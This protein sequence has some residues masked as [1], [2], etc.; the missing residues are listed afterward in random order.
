MA[1][2]TFD[3]DNREVKGGVDHVVVYPKSKNFVGFAWDGVS[4]VGVNPNGGDVNSIWADNICYA[5]IRG[6]EN[7]AGSIKAYDY[8]DEW[9][10]CIG[11]KTHGDYDIVHVHGQ[12]HD[13]FN[14]A[15]RTKTFD[16]DGNWVM[17]T[18]HTLFGLSAGTSE[19]TN[20]TLEE[21]FEPEEFSFDFEGTPVRLG[22]TDLYACDFDFDVPV[23]NDK[24]VLSITDNTLVV[25]GRTFKKADIATAALYIGRLYGTGTAGSGTDASCVSTTALFGTTG[26]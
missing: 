9:K 17:S 4:E 24:E 18:Y 14:L 21:G 23:V 26:S 15:Y 10:P 2:L 12:S 25:N 22:A 3:S 11:I 5:K 6:K 20:K 19:E 13:S 16:K 8:P 7:F 1:I